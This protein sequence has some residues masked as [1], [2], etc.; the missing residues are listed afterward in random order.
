[1]HANEEL[2]NTF[3]SAFQ[4]R[5]GAGMAACYHPDIHF[6]DPVFP[7]LR[8]EKA[9]AMWR[10]LTSRKDS[11][12]VLEFRDITANDASGSAHWD[13]RYTWPNG[14]K[15]L[16]EIDATFEFKD[17]KIIRHVDQFDLWK[18]T[19]M[20]LGP[21]GYVLGWSPIVRNKVRKLAGGRL[22]AFLAGKPI[23]V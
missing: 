1:V 18:W 13:A 11:D 23:P 21:M 7:D 5:D 17:G 10:M 2:I 3:Y 12:L 14:R 8:G 22:E 19:R 20:A 4:K 6:S 9:G 16:N 15:I